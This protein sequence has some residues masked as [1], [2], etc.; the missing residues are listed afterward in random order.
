MDRF[1][2]FIDLEEE[3]HDDEKK[4]LFAQSLFGEAKR[5]F[6]DLPT[7][8]IPTF[9]SFRTLFLD[10]WEENKIPLQILSQYNNLKKWEL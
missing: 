2:D 6:K 3:D 10:R 7:S 1:E 8:Y 4:R 5:W 9:E